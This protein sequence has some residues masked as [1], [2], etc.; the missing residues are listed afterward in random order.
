M[1]AI[2]QL[3]ASISRRVRFPGRERL[4]RS[5]FPLMSFRAHPPEMVTSYDGD[6]HILCTLNSYIDWNVYF[7]GYFA[8]DLSL[9][10][11]SLVQP[12]M[13]VLDVGANIGAYTLLLAKGVGEEGSVFAFEPNPEAFER[14]RVNVALNGYEPR[15]V[16]V[17]VALSTEC[18]WADF[19]VPSDEETNRGL[20]SLHPCA[21]GFP[22]REI[23][24][25]TRT[26]DEFVASE[27]I[28]VV[29]FIKVDTEGH[30]LNVILG[31]EQMIRAQR[32]MIIFEANL[33]DTSR[34]VENL[35]YFRELLQTLR[36]RFFTA[37]YFGKLV[38]LT[39]LQKLPQA[40]IIC[41]AT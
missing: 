3:I 21:R 35:R 23:V 40:D 36:Y 37:S 31:G 4:L 22:G 38:E 1:K 9:A 10:I 30:D 26:L 27:G 19:F 15:V 5:L 16:L 32:P 24:V 6:L 28:E 33:L 25:Q 7:K 39:D 2:H 11:K 13:V 34:S 12:G 14:L 41:I 20:A 17:P 8:P 18:G 29:H